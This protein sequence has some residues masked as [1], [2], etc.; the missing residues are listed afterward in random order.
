MRKIYQGAVGGLL[1]LVAITGCDTKTDTAKA[2]T[3]DP[4][5]AEVTPQNSPLDRLP[6]DYL[7]IEGRIVNVQPSQLSYRRFEDSDPLIH[8]FIYVL[9]EDGNGKKQVLVYPYSRAIFKDN[10]T[11]RYAPLQEGRIDNEV[12]VKS[13][14][15]KGSSSFSSFPI[16][17]EGV[18]A[19]DGIEYK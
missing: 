15:S 2:Y 10:A 9:F 12:F 1:T 19:P 18:I 14:L 17:A 16:V 13:F 3:E 7:T 8:E 6:K 5:L 4:R 11:I